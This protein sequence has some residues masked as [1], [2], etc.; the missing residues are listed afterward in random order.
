MRQLR[1]LQAVRGQR[2]LHGRGDG[3]PCPSRTSASR[4]RSARKRRAA[5]RR[6]RA[7]P[8]LR[9]LG[10]TGTNT[11]PAS[12]PVPPCVLQRS[13]NSAHGAR[14]GRRRRLAIAARGA[15]A[16]ATSAA[17]RVVVGLLHV[18][19]VDP[20]AAWPASH[21]A[22]LLARWRPSN[23]C[24]ICSRREELVVAVAPAQ[25]RQVVEHR[26]GQVA[27]LVVLR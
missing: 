12:R 16:R 17:S 10:A 24:T 23:H 5:R 18:V 13:L 4:S 19:R 26:L 11:S 1:H 7:R 3:W 9:P 27:V 22:G 20:G 6:S 14:A 21:C 15:A 25:A 2:V 8:G